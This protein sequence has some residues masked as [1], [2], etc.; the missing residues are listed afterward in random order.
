MEVFQGQGIVARLF[1][2]LLLFV[3]LVTSARAD[4]IDR[5]RQSLKDI[6]SRIQ[7]LSKR[8]ESSRE[9]EGEVKQEL[10]QLEKE[11]SG[12]QQNSRRLQSRLNALKKDIG[13][14]EKRAGILSKQISEREQY[15]RR[16]LGSVYRRGEMR[17][18]KILFEKN[19]PSLLAENFYYLTRLVRQDRELLK[20]YRDDWR[21]LRDTLQE[22]ENLRSEQQRRLAML[23]ASHK[24]LNKGHQ[25]RKTALSKLKQDSTTLKQ[26]MTGL[27]EKARRL[28]NLLKTLETAKTRE[29][30]GASG[31]ASGEFKQQKGSLPW[32]GQ[33]ALV[34]R[35]GINA[36]KELGTSYESQGIE[37][38]QAAGTP[39]QAVARGKVVFAKPFRGFGNL[40]ILDHGGGYY[41]LYAQASQLV[42]KVGEKVAAGDKIG[43]SGFG[44]SKT[45]YFEIRQRGTPLDPLQW[46]KPRR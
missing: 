29:Y 18:F 6:Q 45:I 36:N 20:S 40:L 10:A 42:K 17:M 23:D 33:G 39:I 31:G 46:L 21:V 1:C 4:D 32:P 12:L 44:D 19:S 34:V 43:I 25:A 26:E 35:F 16:R 37:L 30:S 15:V 7:R 8:L 27:Q 11:L 24:T 22:L 28:R 2:C 14:K 3:C 38:A 5:Q 9:R 13:D 41:S